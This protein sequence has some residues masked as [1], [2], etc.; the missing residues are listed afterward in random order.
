[1]CLESLGPCKN[2]SQLSYM[3]MISSFLSHDKLKRRKKEKKA[4]RGFP[5]LSVTKVH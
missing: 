4:T 1:M 2:W 5:L 3:D